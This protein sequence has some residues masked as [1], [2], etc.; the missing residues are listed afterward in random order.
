MWED[1]YVKKC[2][3][4]GRLK[5]CAATHYNLWP[6]L[7]SLILTHFI[8][9]THYILLIFTVNPRLSRTKTHKTIHRRKRDLTRTWKQ[10]IILIPKVDT[11]VRIAPLENT[12][13]SKVTKALHR[14][15]SGRKTTYSYFFRL[16]FP[17]LNIN[18]LSYYLIFAKL[19]R[20]YWYL[21]IVNG[22]NVFSI[23]HNNRVIEE[24]YFI[25]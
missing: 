24:T 8:G 3:F 2:I 10:N 21:T 25:A 4:K 16:Y 20:M 5:Y 7:F 1:V 23:N 12:R 14:E 11:N 13:W 22:H 19:L 15:N 6:I 9:N 17:L 18:L